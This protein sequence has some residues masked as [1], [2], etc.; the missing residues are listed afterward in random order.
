MPPGGPPSS[1]AQLSVVPQPSELAVPAQCLGCALA[2]QL[3]S[4]RDSVFTPQ[5]AAQ[6][7]EGSFFGVLVHE[8]EHPVCGPVLAS[9]TSF[10]HSSHKDH[11]TVGSLQGSK[12][13]VHWGYLGSQ[14]RHTCALHTLK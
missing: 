6:A 5:A 1:G 14:D 13:G 9:S 7:P 12:A 3:G 2:T 11:G 8:K 4:G 10:M